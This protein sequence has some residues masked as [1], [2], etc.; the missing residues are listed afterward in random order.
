MKKK[1]LIATGVAVLTTSV[2]ATTAR[3]EA[4]GQDGSKGS[5]YMMDTRN[6]FR[7]AAHIN[8]M[9]DYM[10]LETSNGLASERSAEGSFFRENGD[11]S[12]GVALGDTVGNYNSEMTGTGFTEEKNRLRLFIGGDMGV[13]WGASLYYSKS[14]DEA[15]TTENSA[16]GLGLGMSMGDIEAYANVDLKNEAE[17]GT[18]KFEADTGFNVGASYRWSGYT[19]FADYVSG[20]AETTIASV[21]GEADRNSM[22]VGVGRI[23]ELSS[24][25]RLNMDLSYATTTT[26]NGANEVK[27]TALPLTIGFEADAN[28]WLALRGSVSQNIFIGDTETAGKKATNGSTK[29]SGGATLNFG[30]LKVD[31]MLGNRTSSTGGEEIGELGLHYWF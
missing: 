22:T 3:M 4:L 10:A 31:A 27:T 24:T 20:G 28:S 30:K 6:V 17:K 9:K 19:F 7:N 16:M 8:Q 18:D 29:V 5:F 12:Y 13:E 1:I 21:K 11:F 2:F 14:K 26:G 15:N 25:A 23:H